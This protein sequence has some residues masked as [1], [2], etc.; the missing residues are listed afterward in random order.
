MK[1]TANLTE[2]RWLQLLVFPGAAL[3]LLICAW[4]VG[5]K[6]PW[7][8]I[9][10][11]LSF[12]ISVFAL[13]DEVLASIRTKDFRSG[14][15]LLIAAGIICLCTGKAVYAA[16]A[17][18]IRLIAALALPRLRGRVFDLLNTRR[19][20]NPL[21]EQLPSSREDVLLIDT[22]EG[23]LRS[24]LTYLM[25]LLAALVAV[26]T[27]VIGKLPVTEA[28][29]RAAVVLALGGTFPL[30]AAF[31]LS[32]YAAIVS[33]AESG[34]LFRRDTLTSLMGLKLASADAQTPVIIGT[35][36]VF[37]V[38]PEAVGPELML[39]LAATACADT[40]FSAAEKLAVVSKNTGSA[41]IQRQELPGLGVIAK[42]KDIVVLAGSA[43]FMKR[44]GLAV[45]P[46]P[47]SKQV[48]HMGVN[49]HYVGCIDF[50]EQ[51]QA[52]SSE[53]AMDDA[54]FFRFKDTAEAEEKRLPEEK[55]LFLHPA[56]E[57]LS[58]QKG[59]LNAMLGALD[60]LDQITVERCG[61]AGI[62]ALMEQLNCAR[63]GRKGILLV[64][65]IIKAFL[66]LLT[67][68]GICPLWLAVLL[69][70]AG[71]AFS[72]RYS[73]HLLDYIAKY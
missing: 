1:R 18:L 20:L 32:D 53:K 63:L 46:F 73:V 65:L 43:E 12:L 72:Y 25:I 19:D 62:S 22:K 5:T 51:A 68:F 28:L 55:L 60:R 23:L 58:G 34:V 14:L 10:S 4:I 9:L 7:R 41:E 37:P 31:P 45:L 50:S 69:E 39:R 15:L 30:F 26:F 35:A 49:G 33:A 54:G 8:L 71:V 6:G 56:E 52:E 67:V 48:L 66:L 13:R 17:L 21:K 11:L 57:P 47:G 38:R 42:V 3:L 70:M 2:N 29:G 61:R 36:A 16:L 44:S 40:K 24:Y 64:S 59:D 27:V